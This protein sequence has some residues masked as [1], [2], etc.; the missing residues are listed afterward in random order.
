[1]FKLTTLLR[2]GFKRYTTNMIRFATSS[3]A[4][5]PATRL[6]GRIATA[7]AGVFMVLATAQLFS[8]EKFPQ[9]IDDMWLPGVHDGGAMVAAALVVT[10]EVFALPF[11][12]RMR[13]SVAMRVLS[14]VLGWAVGLGW[15]IV[16]IIESV[17]VTALANNGLLGATVELPVGWWAVTVQ[18]AICI[19]IGWASWGLWPLRRRA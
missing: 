12:L 17:S 2:D 8:F 7:L 16:L 11:L 19:M 10:A 18:A 13:L 6:S 1:M 3:T 4:A 15:L 14:M 9:A 5:E